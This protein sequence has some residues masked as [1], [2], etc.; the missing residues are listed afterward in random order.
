[1]GSRLVTGGSAQDE[2]RPG[3]LRQLV[4][5]VGLVE[6][7]WPPHALAV[8]PALRGRHPVAQL[9]AARRLR[10]ARAAQPRPL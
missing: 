10:S 1:M 3:G 5:S 7:V 9:R 6:G 8:P 2:W 4:L